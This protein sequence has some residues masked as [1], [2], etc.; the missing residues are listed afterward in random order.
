MPTLMLLPVTTRQRR[1]TLAV[2]LLILIAGVALVYAT[3]TQVPPT[4]VSST[5]SPTPSLT[6]AVPTSTAIAIP[7]GKTSNPVTTVIGCGTVVVNSVT[8]GEGSGPNTYELL[9][10]TGVYVGRFG[11]DSGQAA[12]GTYICARL[13]PGAP[14]A[15]FSALIK[16][17]E[18]G[19]VPQPTLV[20]TDSCGSVTAYAADG[21]HMLITLT[22]GGTATQYNLEFQFANHTAPTDIGTRLSANTPQLLL[23]TGRQFPADT[24]SPNAISL[25]QY[26]VARVSSCTP[27]SSVNPR[28]AGFT[29]PLGCA[30]VG[31]PAVG[32]DASQWDIDCGAA[33]NDTRG[34]LAS[35]LTQQGWTSCG[36]GLA[37]ASWAKGTARIT[38][39]EGAGGPG[40]YPRLTQPARPA[41]SSSCP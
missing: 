24:G 3:R 31:Q 16:P 17:G 37:N 8:S 10:P 25:R 36:A 22:V 13:I 9:S 18:A 40:G 26:N 29:L 1:A 38:V 28:P 4:A 2:V 6:A 11:W 35:P 27:T 32:A 30:Y 15:G 14:M 33:S 23:L 20:A 39:S 21:A 41:A 7:P 34:T 19:Y 5:S 12:L